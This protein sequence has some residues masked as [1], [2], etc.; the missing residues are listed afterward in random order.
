MQNILTV[1]SLNDPHDETSY[2]HSFTFYAGYHFF[3]CFIH[4]CL[5]KGQLDTML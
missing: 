3:V 4:T 5:T 2:S 1:F